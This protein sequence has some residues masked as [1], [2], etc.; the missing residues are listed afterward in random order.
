LSAGIIQKLSEV[1]DRYRGLNDWELSERTHEFQEWAGHF[2]GEASPIP[3]QDILLAQG[4]LEMI[5]VVE[6]DE[7]ARQTFDDVFGPEP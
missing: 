4:K 1:T 2:H 5:A 6:R 7:L 3:C